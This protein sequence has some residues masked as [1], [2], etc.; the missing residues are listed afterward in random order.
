MTD[1]IVEFKTYLPAGRWF[2]GGEL[3]LILVHDC[4]LDMN[5]TWGARSRNSRSSGNVIGRGKEGRDR[6]TVIKYLC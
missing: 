4:V 6:V 2:R 3:L 5:A 1:T